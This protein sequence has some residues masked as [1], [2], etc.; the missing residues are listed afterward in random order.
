MES[1]AP[2]A[3]ILVGMS[4]GVDSS[5][6]ALLLHRAGYQV[7]GLFMRNW[8]EKDENGVCAATQEYEDVVRVCERIGIPYYSVD[9]VEEYRER[10]FNEFLEDYKAGVTPNPDVLCN[11]EIKFDAFLSRCRELGAD[12]LATGH[13]CQIRRAEGGTELLRGADSTKDQSYF[14]Y[15]V[16]PPA[17]DRVL[18][19]VGHLP[20]A[21]VREIALEAGLPTHDKKDSTGICFIGERRFRPFLS[22][23][24]RPRPGQ[25]RSLDGSVVGTHSGAHLYTLGQRKGLG[26]G[27]P[28]DRSYVVDKDLEKNIVYVERG[29]H[30]PA[31]YVDEL[32]ADALS[33]IAGAPALP[34]NLTA[35]VRYR[36]GDQ[37]CRLEPKGDRVRVVFEVPQRAVTPG[38]HVV[39]YDGDR[40]LGGARIRSLGPSYWHRGLELP[41]N[42]RISL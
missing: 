29:D 37:A 19:P 14:L 38:Q 23:Y 35:K 33:W 42:S 32:E 26:I 27:G 5:V 18:F 10:V 20:K 24:L 7:A 28:G 22:Q 16:R 31:L 6:A 17:L 9:F 30:H 34:A 3:R 13:Y 11:R 15:A 2:G 36:Q 21:R 39:F 25:F 40:C 12:Y 8:D 4:G 41:Q 1:V